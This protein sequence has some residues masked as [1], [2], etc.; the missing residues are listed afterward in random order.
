M[1][2]MTTAA[3]KYLCE[4]PIN[5]DKRAFIKKFFRKYHKGRMMDI[6]I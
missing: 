4:L 5:D 6:N 1:D 2:H 3:A